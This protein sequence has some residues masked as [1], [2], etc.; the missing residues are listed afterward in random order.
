VTF[1]GYVV[2]GSLCCPSRSSIS[3][4]RFPHDTAVYTNGGSDGGFGY[5]HGHEEE[6]ATV[7][8]A[9]SAKGY[10]TATMGKYLN[11]YQPASTLRGI[12]PY[13]PPGWRPRSRC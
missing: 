4:G 8:T 2:T 11:G 12:L 1:N 7:A 6:A 5:F 9:P 3:T 13:V 10:R